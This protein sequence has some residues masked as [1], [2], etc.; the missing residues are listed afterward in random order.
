M[1]I[2][3]GSAGL[4]TNKN[5]GKKNCACLEPVVSKT[6]FSS[7]NNIISTNT[8]TERV[9]NSIRY[10]LGGITRFGNQPILNQYNSS[11][12]FQCYTNSN[13]LVTFLGKTEGQSGGTLGPAK[14]KF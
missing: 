14:N 8:K 3:L 12:Y 6:N 1:P 11:K 4:N 7:G 2:Y 13:D 9:T 5:F 10:S